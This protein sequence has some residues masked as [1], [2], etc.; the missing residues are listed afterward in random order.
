M[1]RTREL[2]VILQCSHIGSVQSC[3]AEC[4]SGAFGVVVSASS[5]YSVGEGIESSSAN[6]EQ[7]VIGE[8]REQVARV[9][10]NL[11]LD[12]LHS[13]L[14]RAASCVILGTM[15]FA[16]KWSSQTASARLRCPCSMLHARCSMLDALCSMLHAR[17]GS[18]ASADGSSRVLQTDRPTTKSRRE[19]CW[20]E[21]GQWHC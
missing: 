9:V 17:G 6:S 2:P 13:H 11:K 19:A 3:C 16:A 5:E 20:S 10:S 4:R 1:I 12:S 15:R 8:R 18:C 21:T 14:H 7:C